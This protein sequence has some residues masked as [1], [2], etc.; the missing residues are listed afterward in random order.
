MARK[1]EA[2]HKSAVDANSHKNTGFSFNKTS[3]LLN[4]VKPCFLPVYSPLYEHG[5]NVWSIYG[6]MLI[7]WIWYTT[8]QVITT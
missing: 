8:W 7:H 3:K 6:V 5:A 2:S 1:M 4:L